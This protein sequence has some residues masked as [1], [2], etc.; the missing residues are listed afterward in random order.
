MTTT[1]KAPQVK[2]LKE[3]LQRLCNEKSVFSWR[4]SSKDELP[5][6]RAVLAAEKRIKRDGAIVHAFNKKVEA[7]QKAETEKKK[8]AY[9]LCEREIFFGDPN[10]ALAMLDAFATKF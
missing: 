7:H 2:F 4:D 10:K 1:K 6:P 3:Y 8:V 9:R 5:K